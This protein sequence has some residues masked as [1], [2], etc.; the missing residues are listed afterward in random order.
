MR[1]LDD[2]DFSV[3]IPR[4]LK[5][6]IRWTLLEIAEV[7]WTAHGRRV[8]EESVTRAVQEAYEVGRGNVLSSDVSQCQNKE[9]C[10]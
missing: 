5:T 10:R 7:V 3:D 4:D 8:V 6:I 2:S 9:K 1:K